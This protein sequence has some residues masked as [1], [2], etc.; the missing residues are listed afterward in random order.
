VDPFPLIGRTREL[1]RLD[2]AL[3]ALDDHGS[4]LLIVGEP[5]IGKTALITQ[6]AGRARGRGMLVLA[7]SGLPSEAQL[8]YAGLHQ[9]LRPVLR[10]AGD[11]PGPQRGAL[12]GA[13]GQADQAV[14]DPMAVALAA[15]NLLRDRSWEAPLVVIAE[16]VQ[17]LDPATAEVLTFVANKI[18]DDR[19]LLIASCRDNAELAGDT[20]FEEIRV[21]GLDEDSSRAVVDAH[22][23]ALD[24]RLR[25][26]VLAQ[27]NGN[28]LALVE[29]SAAWSSRPADSPVEHDIPLTGRCG[30][31]RRP[32]P[33]AMRTSP[34]RSTRWQR[35]RHDAG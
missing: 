35:T 14:T 27:A 26:Q 11:L 20:R 12:L 28:P 13:F 6:A 25:E 30:T 1:E 34:R 4:A 29:L 7:S 10:S 5:G 31:G 33:L 15:L 32:S 18:E 2:Q 3:Q 8:P 21:D 19:I 23:P 24:P 22:L 9:L 16:D 17:W